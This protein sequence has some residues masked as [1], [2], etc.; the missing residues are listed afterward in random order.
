MAL[1]QDDVGDALHRV[2]AAGVAPAKLTT[3]QACILREIALRL[4]RHEAAAILE[5][6]VARKTEEG[7]RGYDERDR[8]ERFAIAAATPALI[9]STDGTAAIRRCKRALPKTAAHRV[10]SVRP[11]P[12][13]TPVSPEVP[14][15]N[16]WTEAAAP[17]RWI[18]ESLTQVRAVLPPDEAPR[19]LIRLAT[20]RAEALVITDQRVITWRTSLRRVENA[21]HDAPLDRVRALYVAS[22]KWGPPILVLEV[23]DDDPVSLRL[24]YRQSAGALTQILADAGFDPPSARPDGL[25][26]E[27]AHEADPQDE[28][29][30]PAQL[31]RE[32]EELVVGRATKA[33]LK[34]VWRM[35]SGGNPPEFIIADGASG[36]L[37]VFKDRCAVVKKGLLTSF[38]AGSTGGGRVTVFHY[39]HVTGIEVNTGIVQSVIEILTPSYQGTANK[40]HWKGLL[41]GPNSD[42][43]SPYTISNTL[44]ISRLLMKEAQ[45]YLDRFTELI[46]EYRRPA[47]SP[48]INLVQGGST[49]AAAYPPP[50]AQSLADELSKLA[51]LHESGALDDA[52]YRDAKRAAIQQATGSS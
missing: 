34:E 26:S 38:L 29:E 27:S 23:E 46:R 41:R 4:D 43:N 33:Q 17:A 49:P 25:V 22:E 31:W 3:S 16:V 21:V 15:E 14:T 50:A 13:P 28:P 51:I 47:A 32:F 30:S 42:S 24:R 20:M 39:E 45:P 44:P 48:V 1:T 36:A 10:A 2:E 9:A 8:A 37:A 5:R 6:H 11:E 19:A 35:A 18:R 12:P 40:D 7:H 52:E